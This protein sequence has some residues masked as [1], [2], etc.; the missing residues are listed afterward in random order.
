MKL[1]N[2]VCTLEQ[3]KKL[4]ELGIVQDSLFSWRKGEFY[5][6]GEWIFEWYV[7]NDAY[8]FEIEPSES[9]SAFTVAELGMMLGGI[10]TI[11]RNEKLGL[12]FAST[13]KGK[14]KALNFTIASALTSELI[15]EIEERSISIQEINNRLSPTIQ[16]SEP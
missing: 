6:T 15:G 14:K 8:D 12:Y 2:Q 7:T 4:K 10:F 3:A 13:P 11:E 16:E 5:N 1:E 9:Y